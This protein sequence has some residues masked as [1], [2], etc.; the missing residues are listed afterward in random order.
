[1]TWFQEAH[2]LNIHAHA[3]GDASRKRDHSRLPCTTTLMLRGISCNSSV[4]PYLE[5]FLACV[6][7]CMCSEMLS[8][9]ET[10]VTSELFT[11]K[12]S[13]RFVHMRAKVSL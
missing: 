1:M 8:G 5:G 10:L 11:H 7:I 12:W 9:P 4:D 3:T 6:K 13:F 2:A